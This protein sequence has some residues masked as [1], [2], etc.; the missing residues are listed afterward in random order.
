MKYKKIMIPIVVS[1]LILIS[2][3]YLNQNPHI[4][5]IGNYKELTYLKTTF[6]ATQDEILS[7]IQYELNSYIRYETIL[8]DIKENDILT[9][10]LYDQNNKLIY[11]C[12]D[13]ILDNANT[14]LK[15]FVL[16]KNVGDELSPVP[17]RVKNSLDVN[18]DVGKIIIK[19]AKRTLP[20]ELTNEFVQKKLGFTTVKEY[21]EYIRSKIINLKESMYTEDLKESLLNQVIS[22]SIF[23]EIDSL[24]EERFNEIKQ[25]YLSYAKL[26]N[27]TYEEV[28][29]NYNIS[30][31]DL[32]KTSVKK[33][34]QYLVSKKILDIENIMT[35]G[36]TYQKAALEYVHYYGYQSINEFENDCGKKYLRQ[37]VTIALAK[38]YIFSVAKPIP[39]T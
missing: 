8:F 13:Y 2:I 16:G 38:N 11:T 36:Y 12:N 37:E 32:Y 35:T 1:L 29:S 22:S 27:L 26:F 39:N 9:L 17:I 34:K 20:L 19:K 33:V 5:K 7:E 3:I 10:D 18:E 25:S 21:E 30:E 6:T 14:D 23:W 31:N 15:E 24:C 28:L 4:K